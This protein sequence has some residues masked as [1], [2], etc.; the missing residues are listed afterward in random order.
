MPGT[1]GAA[2]SS[3]FRQ[4]PESLP[5]APHQPGS[6]SFSISPLREY[7]ATRDV[8][9]RGGLGQTGRGREGGR[10]EGSVNGIDGIFVV[11]C[12]VLDKECL[13]GK[14]DVDPDVLV[15]ELDLWEG[16]LS[17]LRSGVERTTKRMKEN[18]Q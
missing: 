18:I 14:Q 12:G 13:V 11:A 8:E 3:V 16:H 4:S 7:G 5:G 9:G 10:E 2:A 17:V 1:S 6:L 15:E